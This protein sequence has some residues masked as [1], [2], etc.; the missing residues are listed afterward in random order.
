NHDLSGS[1]Q[2]RAAADAALSTSIDAGGCE[3]VEA[4]AEDGSHRTLAYRNGFLHATP[5]LRDELDLDRVVE[6]S[7]AH[8]CTVFTEA[9]PRHDL[10]T[11]SSGFEPRI[12]SRHAR[13]EERR[14]GIFGPVQHV[15]G[16]GGDE[17]PEIE[18]EDF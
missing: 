6:R 4:E 13:G 16:P 17:R 9:V 18:S 14:L 8:Q 12:P 3:F 11:W 7:G 10:R 2:I 15:F 1:V 5:P